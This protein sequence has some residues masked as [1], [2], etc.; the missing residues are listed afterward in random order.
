M[1]RV[2]IGDEPVGAHRPETVAGRL[3]DEIATNVEH[4]KTLE[5]RM[6][7]TRDEILA[8]LDNV[9]AAAAQVKV[10]AEDDVLAAVDER[11]TAL[12]TALGVAPAA[13]PD[14]NQPV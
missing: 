2:P 9:V 8:R 13:E 12:E 6:A 14:P 11:V 5:T 10:N 3:S 7:A 1:R 4:L